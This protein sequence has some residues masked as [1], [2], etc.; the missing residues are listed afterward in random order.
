M[1]YVFKLSG[2]ASNLLKRL[3]HLII[4]E[5]LKVVLIG[6]YTSYITANISKYYNI[7]HCEENGDIK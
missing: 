5:N 2:N 4:S 3:S 1:T 7:L 6:F